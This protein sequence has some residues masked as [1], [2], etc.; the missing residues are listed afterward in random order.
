MFSR[1]MPEPCYSAADFP[2][3]VSNFM[4]HRF[5]LLRK[6]VQL[7]HGHL[8]SGSHTDKL[9]V[10]NEKVCLYGRMKSLHSSASSVV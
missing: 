6:S 10:R 9:Y 3:G 5:D 4:D 7:E 1:V 8:I 2:L